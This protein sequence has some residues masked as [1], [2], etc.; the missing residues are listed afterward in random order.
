MIPQ[1][2]FSTS[3]LVIQLA[4]RNFNLL[5]GVMAYPLCPHPLMRIA[6][7]TAPNVPLLQS[8]S[9]CLNGLDTNLVL[10]D[11]QL[12]S[13]PT[14]RHVTLENA[15]RMFTVNWAILTS[16]TLCDETQNHIGRILQQTKCLIF[17]NIALLD[18]DEHYPHDISLPFLKTLFINERTIGV[19]PPD[20]HS[21]LRSITAP[22]LEIL[23]TALNFLISLCQTSSNDRPHIWKLSLMHFDK[24][25]SL[26]EDDGYAS[27]MPFTHHTLPLQSQELL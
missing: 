21:I 1:A 24:D 9:L 17:C 23:D 8:V 5:L 2:S 26:T 10:P 13:I 25:E 14:L 11:I 4:G 22:I 3:F 15:A 16:I 6:A 18:S 19:H 20:A 12:L 7:L 27:P